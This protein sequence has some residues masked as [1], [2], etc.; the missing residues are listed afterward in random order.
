[1]WGE[2]PRPKRLRERCFR[3]IVRMPTWL[4]WRW[5]RIRPRLG[6]FAH[7]T[8]ERSPG[9]LKWGTPSSSISIGFSIGCSTNHRFLNRVFQYKPTILTIPRLWKAPFDLSQHT[10]ILSR[11][12]T[13]LTSTTGHFIKQVGRGI[14]V[15]HRTWPFIVAD[16]VCVPWFHLLDFLHFFLSLSL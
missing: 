13:D 4:R 5:P 7:I 1:M 15:G 16:E 12:N 9:F 8:W 3:S 2:G 11:K 14:P 10:V 6:T